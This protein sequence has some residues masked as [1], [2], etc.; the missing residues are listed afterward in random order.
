MEHNPDEIWGSQLRAARGAMKKV[1]ASPEDIAAIGITNQRETT[2]VWERSTGNPVY[3]AIVWQC[4]RTAEFCDTLKE[5]GMEEIIR[6][7]TGLVIDPYF[8]A[9]KIRWILDNVEGAR[10]KA[11][12]GELLFGTVDTWLIYKLTGGRVHATDYSNASRTMLFN[13]NTLDWDDELLTLFDIP[14]AMLPTL[15]PSSHRFGETEASLFGSEI[16]IAAAIGDQQ[17][18]LFG[19]GCFDRGDAKNTYGTGGFLLMNTGEA[20]VFSS[21]GLVTS[22]AWGLDGKI[23]YALEGSVF[24]C[25]AAIQWLRDCLG[26]LTSAAESETLAA[27]VKNAVCI[28]SPPLWVLAR[29]IGTP[30]LAVLSSGSPEEP[31]A[32]ISFAPPLRPWHTKR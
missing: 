26:I 23:N 11:E 15:C 19:Q 25:G 5:N 17:A 22:V 31:R 30:M 10:A 14:R 6:A 13:I 24:I 8:S 32:R 4:R 20:P 16:P 28:L 18:A 9:S 3:N 29:P 7:K 12:A 2:I 1:G 27:E 21:N